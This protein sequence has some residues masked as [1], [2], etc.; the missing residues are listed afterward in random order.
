MEE[1]VQLKNHGIEK[2]NK[3]QFEKAKIDFD[4]VINRI[5]T[6]TD[7]QIV[8]KSICYLNLSMCNML[9]KNLDEALNNANEVIKI[10]K[11]K[12]PETEADV[13]QTDKLTTDP[14]IPVLSLAYL[15]R[16]Q[17]F[18]VQAR[19]LDALQEYSIS[20]AL[21]LSDENQKAMKHVL[22]SVGIPEIEQTDADLKP[23]GIL[24]LHFLNEIELMAALTALIKY[25]KDTELSQELIKK[26]NE[27]GASRILIGA[28][29][30]Y[31]DREPIVVGC[32]SAMRVGAEKGVFDCFNGFMV[33]RVVMEHWKQN[34]N[35]IGDSLLLLRLAPSSLYP[36][37][38]RADFIPP[39]C[40]ALELEGLTDDEIDS[41]FFLLYSLTQGEAQLTQVVSEGVLDQIFDRKSDASFMLLSKLIILADVAQRVLTENKVDWI[42]EYV[43]SDEPIFVTSALLSLA[44][45]LCHSKIVLPDEKYR[46]IFPSVWKAVMAHSKDKE[47]TSNGYA[48][49]ALCAPKA[50]Q[51]VT[52]LKAI[53][54][55][56][57]ILAIHTNEPIVAQNIITFIFNC[58]DNGLLNEVIE[59]R[60]VLPTV[61][62]VLTTFPHVQNIVERSVALSVLC[63]HPNK[64]KLLEAGLLEF[65]ESDFL[66]KFVAR[67]GIETPKQ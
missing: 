15:R 60:A 28:M 59:T 42:L 58:A 62:K 12:R 51:Q 67:V 48:T 37:M 23:Y 47:I 29:Q 54:A 46:E 45:F 21:K 40:A 53:R 3:E 22:Q 4:E 17:V 19:P 6:E 11:E 31:I 56:S 34:K 30:L 55:S 49:L 44:Q 14:L 2:M 32:L 33:V 38:M 35:I 10:Y 63:D 50:I 27:S 1:F 39:V 66:K 52:E 18:E 5:P 36:H 9:T 13:A 57:A 24:L 64:V 16:G 43:N 41:I 26:F 20:S 7:E 61:L 25:L 65:P 8:L